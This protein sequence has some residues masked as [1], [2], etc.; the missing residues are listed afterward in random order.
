M[1]GVHPGRVRGDAPGIA[2]LLTVLRDHQGAVT[3][4]LRRH[5]GLSLREALL[6]LP[7]RE[8][9]DLV[10]AI[11]PTDS[12]VARAAQGDLLGAWTPM[13]ENVAM[14]VDALRNHLQFLW[15]QWT[16]PEHERRRARRG[17]APKTPPILPYAVRPQ[18]LTEMHRDHAEVS[19]GGRPRK[20]AP[21]EPRTGMRRMSIEELALLV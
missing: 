18:E 17:R 1:A 9:I 4:D 5:Y 7:A 16:A 14:V 15:A 20:A 13:D 6:E 12:A 2:S 10:D 19:A 8:L 21:G 3:A 11:P